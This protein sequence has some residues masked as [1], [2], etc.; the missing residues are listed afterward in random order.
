MNLQ[1]EEVSFIQINHNLVQVQFRLLQCYFSI[2]PIPSSWRV[3]YIIQLPLD[4]LDP[5][6]VDHLSPYLSTCPIRH[7][8]WLS[9]SY[10]SQGNTVQGSSL[11]KCGQKSSCNVFNA[12]VAAF[13]QIFLS[14][15]HLCTFMMHVPI[16][17]VSQKVTLVIKIHTRVVPNL[18]KEVFLLGPPSTRSLLMKL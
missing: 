15:H 3:S 2:F 9:V 14:S 1:S 10:G 18:S 16:I 6:L 5:T 7:P 17:G 11:H 8:L 4:H 12:V 13:P